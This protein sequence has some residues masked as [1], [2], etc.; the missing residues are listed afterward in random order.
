[1]SATFLAYL[2]YAICNWPFVATKNWKA[3]KKRERAR[4]AHTGYIFSERGQGLKEDSPGV[5]TMFVILDS[6]RRVVMLFASFFNVIYFFL[7]KGGGV[8]NL[9]YKEFLT[10]VFTPVWC[11]HVK[12]WCFFVLNI[13]FF[14]WLST[15]IFSHAS[16]AWHIYSSTIW[17]ICLTINTCEDPFYEK[18]KRAFL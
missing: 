8:V 16:S 18:N 11:F 7:H 12:F 9:L 4:H 15:I 14:V 6:F 1:M 3:R 10:V 5:A 2:I 13:L 17:L